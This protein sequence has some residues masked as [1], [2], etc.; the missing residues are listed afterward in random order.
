MNAQA[1]EVDTFGGRTRHAAVLLQHSASFP[2][3]VFAVVLALVFGGLGWLALA[4][5]DPAD[6]LSVTLFLCG[7]AVATL[8][9]FWFSRLALLHAESRQARIPGVSSAIGSALALAG[10]ATVALPAL[11]LGAGGVPVGLAACMLALA[12]GGGVLMAT[13]PR[14]F[15]LA[16]CFAPMLIGLAVGVLERAPLPEWLAIEWRPSLEQISWLA[17][18]V[19]AFAAWRWFVVVRSIGEPGISPWWQPA[20]ASNPRVGARDGWF[21]G[22]EWNAGLPDWMWPRG[23]TAGAG[24][25]VPV[26]A[27]RALLGTPFAPLS[28]SQIL[29]QLGIGVLVVAYFVLDPM[30]GDGSAGV[31]T[32]GVIGG[33]SVLVVMY[34]QRLEAMY[35]KRSGELDELALLPG[36]GNAASQR[37]HLLDAVFRAPTWATAVVVGLL[38]AIGL[39]MGHAP[40]MIGLTL[41]AGGGMALMSAL[42]CLRPL[43][44]QKLDGLRMLL[45][46]GPGLVLAMGTI[47]YAGKADGSGNVPLVLAL[48][49]M[50]MYAAFGLALRGSWNRFNRRPQPFMQD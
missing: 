21:A 7:L 29:V 40:R 39:M 17:L 6:R 25:Q 32:G 50:A 27:M 22:G 44:G 16:L 11:L 33:G 43:A 23:Q 24:P 2:M 10:L 35:R 4:T 31:M 19:A 41:L 30:G 42:G 47:L 1:M 34:G 36:F 48:V 20:V 38:F 46:A 15:Y 26:R 45:V 14:I 8:W 5:I 18:P 9:S 12:A 49:W 28:G 13:L 3:R 37:R